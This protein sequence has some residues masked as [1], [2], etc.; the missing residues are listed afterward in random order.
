MH[1]PPT[2][3][4]EHEG[5]NLYVDLLRGVSIL[6]VLLLHYTL[7]YKL[8]S[9]P[10]LQWAPAPIL[11]TLFYNGNYGVSVFFVISGFLITSNIVKRYGSLGRIDVAHFYKLRFFRLYPLTVLALVMITVLGLAGLSKF[12]NVVHHANPG[13]GFFVVA[14]LSVLTFW[15]NILMERV[16]Y[17]NYAM[18]IYW[19]LS[20]EEVFYLLYPLALLVLRRGWL[21]A[22]LAG[23]CLVAGPL[24]RGLHRDD[25]LFFMYGNLACVDMLAYGC[26]AA[27]VASRLTL[28]QAARKGLAVLACIAMAWIYMRGISGNEALGATYMGVAAAVFLVT[29]SRLPAGAISRR[30]GAPL[31]WLG[32][33]SYEIYLF[34]IVVLGLL[35]QLVPRA[36]LADDWKLPVLV[37]F[38][39]VAAAT[40]WIAA[41][42]CGDPLNRWL[43]SRY[44]RKGSNA[45]DAAI[46]SSRSQVG[47]GG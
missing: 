14:D 3:S 2:A 38:V 10:L 40:A 28:S 37:V 7:A 6:V 32:Q 44:A 15:H 20:V 13:N 18:N 29:V 8:A 12:S 36:A 24:Y 21:L 35:L 5:R 1:S 45:T 46:S 41:R 17:F 11:H 34:H 47:T 27:I 39:A 19:S 25:E 22:A 23:L 4:A 9:S 31:A 26:I 42:F 16:G 43:R 33:H 30:L